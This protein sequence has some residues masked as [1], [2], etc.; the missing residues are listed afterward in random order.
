MEKEVNFKKNRKP[1][2][3]FILLPLFLVVLGT[4]CAFLLSLTNQLTS[5]AIKE[6]EQKAANEEL[7]EV[8]EMLNNRFGMEIVNNIHDD[9]DNVTES[10]EHV[11]VANESLREIDNKLRSINLISGRGTDNCLY[12]VNGEFYCRD[13]DDNANYIAFRVLHTNNFTTVTT[14]VLINIDD[15]TIKHVQVIGKATTLGASKDNLFI[16]KNDEWNVIGQT[17]DTYRNEFSIISGSTYSSKS[18]KNSIR[19]A[20]NQLKEIGDGLLDEIKKLGGEIQ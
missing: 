4:I 14:I 3:N 10:N 11:K 17:E 15:L 6:N 5:E 13:L 8:R 1:L 2:P 18:V 12:E 7:K 16:N 9:D 19:Y 20:Y